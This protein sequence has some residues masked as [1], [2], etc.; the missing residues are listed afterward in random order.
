[1]RK[2]AISNEGIQAL[3]KILR[4][5]NK[6]IIHLDIGCNQITTD[7]AI[8]LFEALRFHPSLIS[9]NIAN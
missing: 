6:T 2:N 1:L 3:S 7:G 8:S 4:T 9:L 5:K